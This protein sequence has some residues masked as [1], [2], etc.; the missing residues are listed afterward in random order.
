MGR[1]YLVI[2][3]VLALAHDNTAVL[4]KRRIKMIDK[5]FIEKIESLTI[6]TVNEFYGLDY[7]NRA[8][9]LVKPPEASPLNVHT[10]TAILQYCEREMEDKPHIIHII[11]HE[12]VELIG[13][14]KERLRSRETFISTNPAVTPFKFGQQYPVEKFII[15]LQSQF[16]QDDTTAAIL[17]L[18]G[19]LTSSREIST[20]DDG[21]TQRVEAKVGIAKVENVSVPN[22]VTLRPFRTFAE[23]EQPSS[24]FVLRI[25]SDHECALY[26]ADGGAWRH[27]ARESIYSFLAERLEA[28][29]KSD[30]VSII[31]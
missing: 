15:A 23:V 13:R 30:I 22:P 3:L 12:T 1:R 4:I 11:D 2:F 19:N 5:S 26:E 21:V 16:V 6:P 28:I 20:K 8:W 10:L 29:G 9:S 25:N 14:L 27:T 7:S 31:C 24:N 18:V 17:K